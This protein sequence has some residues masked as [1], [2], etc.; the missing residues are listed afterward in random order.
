MSFLQTS[1][2]L[3]NEI[4]IFSEKDYHNVWW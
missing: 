3:N 1:Y 4:C 2:N